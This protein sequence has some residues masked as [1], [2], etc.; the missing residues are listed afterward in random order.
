MIAAD[1]EEVL[2]IEGESFSHPWSRRNF[3]EELDRGTLGRCLVSE[4]GEG[5][6]DGSRVSVEMRICGY[7]M[8]WF[9]A[10]EVHITNLAVASRHRKRGVARS[11]IQRLIDDAVGE[12]AG[13]CVLEVRES[14]LAARSLYEGMGFHHLGVRRRYYRN[15]EDALV[16]GKELRA[17]TESD[18]Q[19]EDGTA[20]P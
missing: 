19:D 9:V 3:L 16:M 20:D 15:G 17:R 5:S 2:V 11:L 18:E 14:N 1:L 8:A 6:G 7:I 13:W 12:G 10:D 4:I